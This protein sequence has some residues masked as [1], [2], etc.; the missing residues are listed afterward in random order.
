[1]EG[2]RPT[3]EKREERFRP[4]RKMGYALDKVASRHSDVGGSAMGQVQGVRDETAS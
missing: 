3:A 1:M 4:L 2:P